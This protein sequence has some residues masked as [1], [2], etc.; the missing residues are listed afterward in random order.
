MGTHQTIEPTP[1]PTR[2]RA[3][4]YELALKKA[5]AQ[6]THGFTGAFKAIDDAAK[7]IEKYLWGGFCP[8]EKPSTPL[9]TVE[10][11]MQRAYEIVEEMHKNNFDLVKKKKLEMIAG[12]IQRFIADVTAVLT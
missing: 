3:I 4:A 10:E 7:E 11:A 2:V 6:V 9:S 8:I 5:D 1:H 12:Q